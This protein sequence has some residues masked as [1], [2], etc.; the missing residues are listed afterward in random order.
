MIELIQRRFSIKIHKFQDLIIIDGGKTHLN[1][2]Q[3]HFKELKFPNI[4]VIAISKGVRRKA[5]F[6]TIHLMNGKK[7]KVD[8]T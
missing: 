4:N 1:H 6:D 3:K 5:D 8:E 2:V 7:L